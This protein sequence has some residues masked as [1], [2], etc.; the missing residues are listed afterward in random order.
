MLR[1]AKICEEGSS[2]WEAFHKFNEQMAEEGPTALQADVEELRAKFDLDGLKLEIYED[3]E[4]QSGVTQLEVL[5]DGEW[6]DFEEDS[7]VL[8]ADVKEE[9]RSFY[10]NAANFEDVLLGE[11]VALREE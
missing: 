6:F 8:N 2:I 1:T 9:L 4:I 3:E 7:T 5:L 10:E 11:F